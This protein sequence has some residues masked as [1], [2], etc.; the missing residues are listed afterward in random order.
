MPLSSAL[1][2]L[3]FHTPSGAMHSDYVCIPH[4]LSFSGDYGAAMHGAYVPPWLLWGFRSLL[5]VYAVHCLVLHASNKFPV[6]KPR[7]CWY[8]T[9]VLPIYW[10]HLST[11][12]IHTLLW[13]QHQVSVFLLIVVNL[14]YFP[15]I[16]DLIVNIYTQLS[17]PGTWRPHCEKMH[18]YPVPGTHSYPYPAPGYTI[19]C[20]ILQLRT[21]N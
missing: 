14:Y 8:E 21:Y 9:T 12:N 13:N 1:A 2:L 3:G 5:P 11:C 4:L 20:T 18:P 6:W 17:N 10:Q 7:E 19:S 15:W 16:M